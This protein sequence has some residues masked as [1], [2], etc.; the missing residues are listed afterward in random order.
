MRSDGTWSACRD[1][2][3]SCKVVMSDHYP[4]ATVTHGEWGDEY[5]AIRSVDGKVEAYM[6]RDVYGTV[7]EDAARRNALLIA[8]APDLYAALER[9][10][11]CIRTGADVAETLLCIEQT[12]N[13]AR[14]GDKV[15]QPRDFVA[16]IRTERT[17]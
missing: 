1:G 9:A 14:E 13:R 17:T 2:K 8:A 7:S 3:C 5:P 11:Y 16:L 10:A 15:E 12:L 4:V 6:H